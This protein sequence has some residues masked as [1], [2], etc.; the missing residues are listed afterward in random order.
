MNLELSVQEINIVL[1]ALGQRPFVEVAEL[2]VKV[3]KQAQEGLKKE[4]AKTQEG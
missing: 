4:E 2:V 1:N 3:Q